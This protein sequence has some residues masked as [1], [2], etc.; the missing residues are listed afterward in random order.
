MSLLVAII[1]VMM[2][3][4]YVESTEETLRTQYGSEVAVVVAKTDIRELDL[5]D[6][7]NLTTINV[8]KKFRQEGAGA[9][10]EDFL[11]GLSRAPIKAGQQVTRQIVTRA[12]P[13]TGLSRQVAVGKRAVTV[14]VSDHNGVAKLIKPGDRIDVLVKIDRGQGKKELMEV[15]TLL[16]DVIVLATGVHVTNTLPGIL[17]QDPSKPEIKTKKALGEYV[18]YNTL[19]LEADPYQ[20]Q[21]LVFAETALDGVYV[22]L[23]NNDDNSK[24]PVEKVMLSDVTVKDA[25]RVPASQAPA[26]P[27]GAAPQPG[28]R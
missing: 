8:P 16:Q 4:S 20:A 17:E 12:G 10:V 19:T 25:I 18:N 5:L 13:R 3:Y 28:S 6:E 27:Q 9:K 15:K 22:I 2:I 7:T 23:R 14:R 11:G 21:M 26:A 1:A 24:D